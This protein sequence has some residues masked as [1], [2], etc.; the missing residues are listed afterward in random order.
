MIP[1]CSFSIVPKTLLYFSQKPRVVCLRFSL[2]SGRKSLLLFF[3]FFSASW[4]KKS[5]YS[6]PGPK[7]LMGEGVNCSVVL[8]PQGMC[9]DCP[10]RLGNPSYNDLLTVDFFVYS[11]CHQCCDCISLGAS[12]ANS[13]QWQTSRSACPLHT[14]YN[15]CAVLPKVRWFMN[16]GGGSTDGHGSKPMCH[17]LHAWFKGW[18][19]NPNAELKNSLHHFLNSILLSTSCSVPGTWNRCFD[20]NKRKGTLETGYSSPPPSNPSKEPPLSLISETGNSTPGPSLN[21]SAQGNVRGRNTG[22]IVAGVVFSLATISGLIFALFWWRRRKNAI[23]YF[24]SHG[25]AQIISFNTT[26]THKESFPQSISS[27]YKHENIDTLAKDF[28]I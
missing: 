9:S 6:C 19:K 10:I 14:W 24:R 5:F 20:L 22:V 12:K 25:I 28:H 21:P 18:K 8:L 11:I 13:G 4:A 23:P 2:L 1:F 7:G 15:I 17:D 3:I 26:D 27:I 16:I